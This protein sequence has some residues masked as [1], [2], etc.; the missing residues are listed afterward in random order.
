MPPFEVATQVVAGNDGEVWAGFE[1]RF[2]PAVHSVSPLLRR[3][4]IK[5]MMPIAAM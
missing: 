5:M 1:E 3:Q 4:R 2:Y